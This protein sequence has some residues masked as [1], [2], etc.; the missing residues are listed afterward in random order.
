M[1][2]GFAIVDQGRGHI[3]L[4]FL[5]LK[6]CRQ[7]YQNSC[8][9]LLLNLTASDYVLYNDPL[10]LFYRQVNQCCWYSTAEHLFCTLCCQKEDSN[11]EETWELYQVAPLLSYKR[12]RTDIL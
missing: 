3:L 4:A 12:I 2:F 10:D 1:L 11:Q 7:Q 8:F 6:F 5:A 9:P